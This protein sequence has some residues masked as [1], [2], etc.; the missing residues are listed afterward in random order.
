MSNKARTAFPEINDMARRINEMGSLG[1]ILGPEMD[2]MVEKVK[3]L[4]GNSGNH[5]DLVGLRRETP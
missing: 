5:A 1:K 3:F 2:A 4:F